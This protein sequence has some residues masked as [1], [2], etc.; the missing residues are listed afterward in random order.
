MAESLFV[1]AVPAGQAATMKHQHY[2]SLRRAGRRVDV[3]AIL[4][5][6]VIDGGNVIEVGRHVHLCLRDGGAG[7]YDH[8]DDKMKHAFR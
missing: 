6:R 7:D 1:L 2:G 5:V 4:T 3:E 8:G